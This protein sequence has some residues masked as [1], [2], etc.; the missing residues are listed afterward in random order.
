MG[1]PTRSATCV[2]ALLSG[3]ISSPVEAATAGEAEQRVEITGSLIRRA[4]AEAALPVVVLKGEDL[5]RAG[6]RT[7]EEALQYVAQNQ[8]TV[9][10]SQSVHLAHGGAAWADLRALGVGL[11]LV[12]LNGQRVVKN[13]YDDFATD[14]NALPMVLIDR[15]EVLTGGASST[16]GTDAGAGVINILTKREFSGGELALSARRPQA[17]GGDQNGAQLSFGRGSLQADG[18]NLYAGIDLLRADAIRARDR[19]FSRRQQPEFGLHRT[20]TN[21]FPGNYTQQ[22][23]IDSTNPTLPNCDPPQSVPTPPTS[24]PNACRFDTWAYEDLVP[25]VQRWSMLARGTHTLGATQTV[26][27]EYFRAFNRIEARIGPTPLTAMPMTSASPYFPGG[28]AGVPVSDPALDRSRPIAVAWRMVAAGPREHSDEN[29]TQR[30][31]AEWMGQHARW[32]F[33]L[34]AHASTADVRK[35]FGSGYVNR[36]RIV[37]GVAGANGAPFLNPFGDQTADGQAWIEGSEITGEVQRARGRLSSING[38]IGGDLLQWP[39]G[40]VSLAL[41]AELRKESLDFRNDFNRIRQAESS[42][43]AL[44][45]DIAGKTRSRA[46]YAELNMPLLRDRTLARSLE[47][48]LSVRHDR[49]DSFGGATNPKASL[50]WQPAERLLL[51]ASY[52]RGFTTPPLTLLYRPTVIG[53]TPRLNDP[54]L[55]PGGVP[56]PGADR[57]RDC[58]ATFARL[59]GGNPELQPM[60]SR[61][62]SAG[63]VLDLTRQV[64]ISIDRFDYRVTD[65]LGAPATPLVFDDPVS[66]AAFFVRCSQLTPERAAALGCVAGP[67]DPLA[68]IDGRWLNMG[69]SLSRGTDLGVTV[70]SD[71]GPAGRFTLNWNGSYLSRVASQ[72]LKGG[73]FVEFAGRWVGAAVPRWQHTVQLAWERGTWSARLVNRYKSGYDDANVDTLDNAVFGHNRVGAWSVFDVTL[74]YRGIDNIMVTAGLLNALDTDPPFS[75]QNALFQTGYDARIASPEGRALFLQASWRFR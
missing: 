28:A 46:L 2:L 34:T 33:R 27:L 66:Y 53:S 56:T 43:L 22:P 16:Y 62:W 50:R 8:P 19:D 31:L 64:S 3:G 26:A 13:P 30:L 9:G 24:A 20:A 47:L 23:A 6:V 69:T 7:V 72:Q 35:A 12:L 67:V 58:N 71:P 54:L 42:G 44:A 36:R 75:N 68:Y 17:A 1:T 52:N 15:I 51:R 4:E 70:R 41:G 57:S 32:D 45:E 40:P 29:T 18:Y 55:C 21:T 65:T 63:I 25:A 59:S 39:S 73:P 37:D 49:Y 11:T 38:T 5:A 14:L 10:T 61:G 74:S 60:R 48:A